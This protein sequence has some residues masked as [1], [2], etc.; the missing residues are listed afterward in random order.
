MWPALLVTAAESTAGGVIAHGI[1]FLARAAW[2]FD[3]TDNLWMAVALFVPYVPAALL[4]GPVARRVGSRRTLQAANLVMI[5]A[6]LGLAAGLPPWT[7][8]LLAP[9]YNGLAGMV[10]PIIEGYVAGGQHGPGLHRAVGRFNLTWSLTLAPALW[11]VA[12]AGDDLRISFGAL[13]ALHLL[14]AAAASRLPANPPPADHGAEPV[15]EH[16]P[17]L[18]RSCRVL[19]PVSYVLLDALSP[20][21]PGAWEK[22]GVAASWAALLS[23]LWMLARFATFVG[24]VRWSGWRGRPAALLVGAVLLVSGFA[25]SLSAGTIPALLA[26]LLAFGA[27]Q[28]T[29]YYQ[30]LYYGMAVGKSEVESGGT[31]EAVIGLGYLGGPGLA[32]LGLAVG[33]PPIHAVGAVASGGV[34]V[35]LWPWLRRIR[36]RQG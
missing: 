7:A 11:I 17:K 22:V 12:L 5:V 23:S 16:Y 33:V 36:S 1:Y 24:L 31:H 25:V 35:G 29:L 21:L 15:A 27:G 19:L 26:G 3:D 9:L 4:A 8:W 30:A 2:G 28:G 20:L 32:L 34:L 14:V 18:L 13:V 6:G 10:W